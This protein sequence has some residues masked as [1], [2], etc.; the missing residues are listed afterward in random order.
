MRTYLNYV[1]ALSI[2][3][4]PLFANADA[5]RISSMGY[6]G[7]LNVSIIE[8]GQ[9]QMSY[10]VSAN[11]TAVYQCLEE[12]FVCPSTLN[13]A[14]ISATVIGTANLK[15]LATPGITLGMVASK[16]V[17]SPPTSTLVCD[18]G[19]VFDDEISAVL[20]AITYD[21]ITVLNR[22]QNTSYKATPARVTA[23]FHTCP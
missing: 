10:Q 22:T 8:A 12:N 4:F 2:L 17:V 15:A 11:A 6:E 14:E 1:V 13:K 9:P 3:C 20:M 23:T 21:D 5:V 18:V 19:G 7:D 16:V